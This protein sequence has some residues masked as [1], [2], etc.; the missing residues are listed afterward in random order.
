MKLHKQLI[1]AVS[2]ATMLSGTVQAN[3]ESLIPYISE[4]NATGEI[5]RIYDEVKGAFGM[6]PAP[7]K[8]HSVSPELLKN[9]WDYFDVVSKNKNFTQKFLAIMRM[10]I[11]SSGVFQ[12]CD[13]CVDG[14][15]MVLK[16]MFDMD[17]G[18]IKDIQ[19]NPEK[20]KL[21]QREGLMLKFLLTSTKDPKSL[22]RSSFDQL[23]KSGW[24][25]KDIF[26]GLKMATQMVAAIY[27]VNSLK[28]PSNFN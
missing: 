24:S 28:I 22:T 9:H 13:Y 5:K 8:Q 7:I 16:S 12:Q 23:R 20:A 14:N 1:M 18:L 10:S 21:D 27:M 15:A 25:D 26:E 3:D 4:N 2:L 11:A 6:I 17:D 19:N